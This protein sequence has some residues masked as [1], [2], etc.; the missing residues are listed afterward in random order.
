MRQPGDRPGDAAEGPDEL[1]LGVELRVAIDNSLGRPGRAG[2]EQD[3]RLVVGGRCATRPAG[4]RARSGGQTTVKRA[5]SSSPPMGI[6]ASRNRR[7]GLGRSPMTI[8][9][10]VSAV[11]QRPRLPPVPRSDSPGRRYAS[12]SAIRRQPSPVSA[13]TIAAPARQQAYTAAV[14]SS[15][16]GTSS[17]TR[18][19]G[20]HAGMA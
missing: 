8:R 2:G 12:A 13:T 3:R 10:P 7:I 6:D 1:E 11:Q 5:R 17:A 15:P 19:P 20:L 16:G 9:A 4:D 14:S 18:W